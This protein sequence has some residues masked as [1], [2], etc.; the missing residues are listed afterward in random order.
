M[1]I[2]RRALLSALPPAILGGCAFAPMLEYRFALRMAVQCNDRLF[3]DTSVIGVRSRKLNSLWN[4][5]QPWVNEIIGRAPIVDLRDYGVLCS[6]LTP[7]SE[8]AGPPEG[9][10]INLP[11]LLDDPTASPQ[12]AELRR[13]ATPDL[14][15]APLLQSKATIIVPNELA[16]QLAWIS[17]QNDLGTCHIS[18]TSNIRAVTGGIIADVS[19]SLRRVDTPPTL[20]LPNTGEWRRALG[21][22]T[23]APRGNHC[24]ALNQLLAQRYTQD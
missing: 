2:T 17:N 6:L 16:P 23:S 20:T 1:A 19:F 11:F 13:T 15:L 21:D 8:L 4:P 18:S 10:I 22:N 5:E 9:K 12:H 7:A 14:S 24:I 3:E